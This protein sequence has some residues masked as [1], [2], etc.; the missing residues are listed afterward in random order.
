[1]AAI[2]ASWS[3]AELGSGEVY[4]AGRRVKAAA[5]GSGGPQRQVIQPAGPRRYPPFDVLDSQ[6]RSVLGVASGPEHVG[7]RDGPGSSDRPTQI[8]SACMVPCLRWAP[9]ER[10]S[11]AGPRNAMCKPGASSP[12]RST[13]GRP[14][15]GCQRTT[16]AW[17]CRIGPVVDAAQPPSGHGSAWPPHARAS[18]AGCGL[19]GV[20][21]LDHEV[22]DSGEGQIRD[23]VVGSQPVRGRPGNM[24]VQRRRRSGRCVVVAYSAP[25]CC[26]RTSSDMWRR[27]RS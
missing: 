11:R 4:H 22:R 9:P 19:D 10:N 15:A 23:Q 6:Y 25:R 13:T 24:W 20:R 26:I 3:P 5:R 8:A 27:V 17:S 7:H 18:A 2:P 14:C 1:M 16:Q 12:R 21:V